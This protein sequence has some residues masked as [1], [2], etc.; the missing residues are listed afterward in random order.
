LSFLLLRKEPC[1]K[2]ETLF[3]LTGGAG[4]CNGSAC[5]V[6]QINASLDALGLRS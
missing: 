6:C 5:A 3:A 4:L 1:V 2:C